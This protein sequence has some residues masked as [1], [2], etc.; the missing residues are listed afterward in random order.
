MFPTKLESEQPSSTSHWA[1]EAQRPF[2]WVAYRECSQHGRCT[3]ATIK[4]LGYP[5]RDSLHAWIQALHPRL[6]S[7]RLRLRTRYSAAVVRGIERLLLTHLHAV[8]PSS[9]L[10]Q[11][12]HYLHRQWPK[13]VRF[14]TNGT[15]SLDSNPVENAIRPFV[16]GRRS[17]L[18]ADTVG[19]QCQHQF[20]LADRDSE[21]QQHRALPIPRGALQEAAIGTGR[22]RLR[23]SDALEHQTGRCVK[24][25]LACR[26]QHQAQ[27]RDWFS[28]TCTGQQGPTQ[29]SPKNTPGLVDPTP[30]V[31]QCGRMVRVSVTRHGTG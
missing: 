18:F 31:P 16:V 21:G 2:T 30:Q 1:S 8:A 14:L 28:L 27:A 11:A 3:A 10:G 9:S 5:S 19:G 13:L 12:P 22:R 24:A 23:G 20:V 4:T 7:R 17:C 25:L 6:C 29:Q 15:W 26:F